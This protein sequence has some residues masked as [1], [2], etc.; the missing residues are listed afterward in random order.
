VPIWLG[1]YRRFSFRLC[2]KGSP[3]AYFPRF[4]QQNAIGVDNCR[5]PLHRGVLL[6]P[7]QEPVAVHPCL[8]LPDFARH[9]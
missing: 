6:L 1:G 9:R 7:H 5:L 3:T 8:L 4:L 2:A